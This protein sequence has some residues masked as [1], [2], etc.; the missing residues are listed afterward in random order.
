LTNQTHITTKTKTSNKQQATSNSLKQPPQ[1][2]Q[3][4]NQSKQNKIMFSAAVSK[5]T[6]SAFRRVA[7]TSQSLNGPRT[8]NATVG[9]V[10]Y[11]N[12]HE[13]LSMDLMKQHG[14]ATPAGYVASSPEEAE[15]I[16][17]HKLNKRT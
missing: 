15:N 11:L 6:T 9:A 14:I 17:L 13:Y 5:R 2:P 4:Q 16:F 1:S 7:G 8:A 12:L 10:R 3:K